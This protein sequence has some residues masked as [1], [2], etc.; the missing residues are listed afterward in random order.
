MEQHFAEV[1][2]P[3]QGEH[4]AATVSFF[5]QLEDGNPMG[6]ARIFQ[7][8]EIFPADDPR[9]CIFEGAGLRLR[10]VR[11]P[12]RARITLSVGVDHVPTPATVDAPNGTTVSFTS[13]PPP[14]MKTTPASQ[15]TP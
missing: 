15:R 3:T 8:E 10:L 6:S 12:E 4:F 5:Q 7:M 2:L 13:I 11:K 9:E 1:L 14:W